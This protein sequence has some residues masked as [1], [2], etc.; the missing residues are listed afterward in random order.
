M[1][2]REI[3]LKIA[4]KKY[5]NLINSILDVLI[6]LNLDLIITYINPQVYEVFGYSYDEVIGKKSLDFVHPDDISRT[7]EA[8]KRSTKTREII[9]TELRILHK[10]GH[11]V[12]IN[13]KGRVVEIE[14]QDKV[15]AILRDIT[16]ITEAQQK[17]KESDQKYRE[18]IENIEDGYF[19]VDLKGNYTYVNDYTCR[20]L[21]LS[22][23]ELI[24][25]SYGLV[26]NSKSLKEVYET[27]N[28]VY[29]K[30]LPRGNFESQ[31]IRN[32]GEV[33][34][35]EGTFYLK[36]DSF[37]KKVGFYGLTRDITE[38]KKLELELRES[39]RKFRSIFNSIP[40][41][42]FL[43]N[44]DSTIL[45]F[46]GE[47]EDLYIPPEEFLGKKMIDVLPKEVSDLFQ[48]A[49]HQT[50]NSK[51]PQIIDYSL[52]IGEDLRYFE[53][54]HLYFD[55]NTI[56][57]F[58][59]N[60]TERKNAE[61]KHKLSEAKYKEAYNR[62]ELY[63]D[64][65][66]HD[67]N[68]I[69][70]NIKLSIDLSEKYLNKPEK[71]LEI[72]NLYELIRN[73]FGRG[74]RLINNVRKLSNLEGLE[75]S[76]K[77]VDVNKVLKDAI[78]YIQKSLQIMDIVI[79]IESTEKKIFAIANDFL[80]DIFENIILNAVNYN[81]NPKKEILIKIS[82]ESKNSIKC[83]KFEFIDNGIG[84]SNK[85]KEVIFREGFIKEK[86][87][88]GMGFGLTLVKKIIE[89]YKGTIWIED[90]VEGDYTHG[91]NFIFLIPEAEK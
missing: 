12:P 71:K 20:Y 91:S 36:Y 79:K 11:F 63:K 23:K 2:K 33:R 58:I 62:A 90:R 31:V 14:S 81:E 32:D 4:E 50:L 73:Q 53:A 56:A 24:G 54:R 17:V 74:S 15:V 80:I 42:F 16:E 57:I 55:E 40:D 22:R 84:I 46:S 18:I 38:R 39:E 37:G 8:I 88:K 72:K 45:D 61:E 47:Q 13:A 41:L 30:N 34:T 43:V 66:Y 1:S 25:K 10:K 70:S 48:S 6:E 85:R 64:L 51:E 35:F 19:E 3:D 49:M 29:E 89:S 5:F 21:G 87:S 83:I 44:K 27:F 82:K 86:G 69:L 28:H 59:R 26:L 77:L 76:L 9:S 60:I 52:V 67:I 7:I 78:N 65:F 75:S 68:N